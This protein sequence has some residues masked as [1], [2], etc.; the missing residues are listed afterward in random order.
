MTFSFARYSTR[1][2]DALFSWKNDFLNALS[3]YISAHNREDGVKSIIIGLIVVE[4][5]R[6]HERLFRPRRNQ[7]IKHR[8]FT[9]LYGQPQVLQDVLVWELQI[10]A[11]E[12]LSRG[13]PHDREVFLVEAIIHSFRQVSGF[14]HRKNLR[15]D[16]LH[17]EALMRQFVQAQAGT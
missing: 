9:D 4:A 15:V 7:F 1:A 3:G 2:T 5:D 10:L 12:F 6:A 13:T 14:V 16:F 17:L 11:E 8:A